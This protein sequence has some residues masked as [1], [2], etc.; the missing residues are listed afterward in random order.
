MAPSKNLGT[1]DDP[2]VSLVGNSHKAAIGQIGQICPISRLD[3]GS[4]ANPLRVEDAIHI[5]GAER[6]A[7]GEAGGIRPSVEEAQIIRPA[8]FRAGAVPGGKCHRLVKKEEFGIGVG[9]HHRPPAG[10]EFQEAGHP[11]GVTPAGRSEDAPLVV[12]N[13][14]IASQGSPRGDGLDGGERCYAVLLRQGIGPGRDP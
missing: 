3:P 10:F 5:D 12:K 13:P 9:R 7:I 8:A 11:M 4:L 6:G 14:S 2:G 1:G